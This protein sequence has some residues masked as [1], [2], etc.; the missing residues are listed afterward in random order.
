M[1]TTVYKDQ[2]KDCEGL[3]GRDKTM[4]KMYFA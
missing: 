1:C 2:I 4:L 3:Y